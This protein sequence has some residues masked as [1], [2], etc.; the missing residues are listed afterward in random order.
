MSQNIQI[1]GQKPA[2]LYPQ[3]T[4]LPV[5]S[6]KLP[7]EEYFE[8][9]KDAVNGNISLPLFTPFSSAPVDIQVDG[10]SIDQDAITTNILSL[11]TAPLI[12]GDLEETMRNILVQ[13]M[14]YLQDNTW[15][16][17]G[18]CTAETFGHYR[19]PMPQKMPYIGYTPQDH[20]IPQ[21]KA[22]LA[23]TTNDLEKEL[24]SSYVGAYLD[25]S[26][27]AMFITVK[28]ESTWAN[29]LAHAAAIFNTHQAAGN[30][31]PDTINMAQTLQK[32]PIKNE[33][34]LSFILSQKDEVLETTAQQNQPYSFMRILLNAIASFSGANPSEMFVQPIDL[35]EFYFPTNIVIMNL[36]E[37]AHA[38]A[39]EIRKEWK[40]TKKGFDIAKQLKI[41]SLKAL[42]TAPAVGRTNMQKG[43]YAIN[44]YNAVQRAANRKFSEKPV[45][46]KR[47]VAMMVKVMKSRETSKMT[48]NTYSVDKLTYM[49]PN[50]RR[51]DDPNAIG[52]MKNTKYRPDIHVYLD[53]S[54][55]IS[56]DMYSDTVMNLI[57]LAQK[58]QVNFYFTTFSHYI[59]E[60]YKVEVKGRPVSEIYKEIQGIP[61]ASG[62]TDFTL[63]WSKIKSI[64]KWNRMNG[65]SYQI[66]FMITDFCCGVGRNSKFRKG[67]PEVDNLYYVPI[68]T[69]QSNW[70]NVRSWAETFAKNMIMAGDSDIKRRMLL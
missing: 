17:K 5:I 36:D 55:S 44:Q 27:D 28:S 32:T 23:D 40:V 34:Q 59:T 45:S 30:L 65:R 6:P 52:K 1:S 22:L 29:F 2:Q 37:Y 60:A 9:I 7:P 24:W 64:D 47:L 15:N 58:S 35:A 33:L 21:A 46:S 61:K 42:R 57:R 25:Q 48:S 8:A 56:E 10:Q 43:Q 13:S 11:F 4:T 3:H 62:G 38:T 41:I 69:S 14:R 31:D 26:V 16:V 54:G 12:Q 66:N 50:R 68:S 63:V 70:R 49:R 20:V 18:Q 51:P 39:E 67:T 19:I 53:C